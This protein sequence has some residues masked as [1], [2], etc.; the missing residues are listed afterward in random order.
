MISS[1]AVENKQRGLA[2]VQKLR[3]EL[4]AIIDSKK[5]ERGMGKFCRHSH[6]SFLKPKA[7]RPLVLG[8]L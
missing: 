1:L 7:K 4:Q 5:V 2:H 3:V 6:V 8:A